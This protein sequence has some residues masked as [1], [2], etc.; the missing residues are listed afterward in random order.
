MSPKST[1][2]SVGASDPGISREAVYEELERILASPLFGRSERLCRFL[3]FAVESALRGEA[4]QVK[5]YVVG[6]EVFG[7]GAA[8]DPRVD[9][10]VRVEA[11]RL[12]SRLKDWYKGAGSSSA[13]I[14]ELPTG[15]YTAVFRQRGAVAAPQEHVIAVMPFTNLN[16]DA[17]GD[18]LSDGITEELIHALTKLS[19]LRVVAWNSAVRMKGREQDLAAIRERLG[20]EAFL[21]G[22]IRRAPGHLR[23]TAQLIETATGYYLWSE[24]WDRAATDLFAIEEE[25]AQAIANKLRVPLSAAGGDRLARQSADI[26][27]YELYLKGRFYWNTRTREGIDISIRCFEE[28]AAID[29]QWPLA[30]SG[31][32]DAYALRAD[33]GYT[34]PEESMPAARRAAETALRLDPSLG[35]AWNSLAFIR[36]MYDWEWEDAER[37][38]RRAIELKPG[39]A[40]AHLWYGIDFL[41]SL[42]R[43]DEA[44]REIDIGVSLDPLSPSMLTAR[45]LVSMFAGQYDDAL[46]VFNQIIEQYPLSWRPWG[47][48]A[49]LHSV[50]GEYRESIELFEKAQALGGSE[51]ALLGALGQTYA[52]AGREREAREALEQLVHLAQ[53]RFVPVTCMALI[54]GALGE[55][56]TALDWLENGAERRDLRLTVIAAHPA[57]RCFRGNQRFEMLLRRVGLSK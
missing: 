43:F 42:S 10:V 57:Y 27:C 36:S 21:R 5:E 24:A 34:T 38:Y 20:A 50:V 12:R 8:F 15:C 18:Y 44:L 23:V 46:R 6:S 13:V 19:G 1:N 55:T 22:S 31:L 32:A 2:R 47:N 29:P 9:P 28:A 52:L 33:Y 45:G 53:S 4:N 51:P 41:A 26:A 49:R 25:I 30:W 54:H 7:R 39:Y 37:M 56:D 14:I 40:L 3:R 35:E 11:R 48:L 17:E 16:G